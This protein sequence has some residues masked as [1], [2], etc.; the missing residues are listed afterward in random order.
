MRSRW[1]DLAQ[2][3]GILE[4]GDEGE[5]SHDVA[6]ID[7]PRQVARRPTSMQLVTPAG[8]TLVAQDPNLAQLV[9]NYRNLSQQDLLAIIAGWSVAQVQQGRQNA[10]IVT[11]QQAGTAK[12]YIL[13]F[14]TPCFGLIL[15][16][17]GPGQATYRLNE[18]GAVLAQIIKAN[19][20]VNLNFPTAVIKKVYLT[21]I[22]NTG[23]Y[24]TLRF[25][26]IY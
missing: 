21:Y 1:G 13:D 8:G 9:E 7:T 17:D 3:A 26:G 18:S 22:Y 5:T 4:T 10:G 16:N 20:V 11:I 23:G 19:E 25:T 12:Q 24:V 15:T 14:D 6:P 2:E